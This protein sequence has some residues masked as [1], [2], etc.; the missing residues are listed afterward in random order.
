MGRTTSRSALHCELF[1]SGTDPHLSVTHRRVPN[2]GLSLSDQTI[3]T[4][5]VTIQLCSNFGVCLNGNKIAL[6]DIGLGSD[7]RERGM[8]VE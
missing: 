1:H 2:T 3:D 6:V 5:T 7:T 8:P 4:H